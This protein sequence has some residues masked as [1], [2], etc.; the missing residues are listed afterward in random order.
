MLSSHDVHTALRVRLH[1]MGLTRVV[2][3]RM[4]E[5]SR[6]ANGQICRSQ[7]YSFVPYCSG[8][9]NPPLTCLFAKIKFSQC[10]RRQFETALFTRFHIY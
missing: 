7:R 5:A 6:G 9:S 8:T 1:V 4:F 10:S 2:G 3:H